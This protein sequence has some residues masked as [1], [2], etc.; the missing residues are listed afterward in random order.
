MGETASRDRLRRADLR[1]RLVRVPLRVAPPRSRVRTNQ[2]TAHVVVQRRCHRSAYSH[3]CALSSALPAQV[4]EYRD[5]WHPNHRLTNH[6]LLL[7]GCSQLWRLELL[8]GAVA[9]FGGP[10]VE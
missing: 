3:T 1:R 2:L 5:L 9:A 4:S 6:R 10:L 8:R 7:I